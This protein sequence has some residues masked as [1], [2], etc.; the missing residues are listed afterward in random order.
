MKFLCT[1]KYI[2]LSCFQLQ[3]EK[4]STKYLSFISPSGNISY[5]Q[6]IKEFA[7]YLQDEITNSIKRD[8]AETLYVKLKEIISQSGEQNKNIR[9]VWAHSFL[10]IYN[11]YYVPSK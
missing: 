4:Q 9:D 5:A 2:T 1:P 10:F 7:A 11:S 3:E 6:G 8:I